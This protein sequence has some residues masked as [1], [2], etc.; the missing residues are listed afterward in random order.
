MSIADS[1]LDNN[2]TTTGIVVVVYKDPDTPADTAAVIERT[3]DIAG[4][5]DTGSWQV[6][7]TIQPCDNAGSHF[8]DYLPLTN[9][10]YWYR[11]RHTHPAFN[12]SD[13]IFETSGSA[14][15]IPDID[16]ASKP[17]LLS[18]TPL[19]LVMVV[20]GSTT[21]SWTVVP[22]V[23][24]PVVGTLVTPPTITPFVSGN[25]GNI[26]TGSLT[27]SF[28]INRPT[29]SAALVDSFVVFRSISQGYLSGFD[30]VE[31]RGTS[32]TLTSSSFL[33]LKLS[34]TSSTLT[35]VGVSASVNTSQPVG[36]GILSS[37][38]VGTI[39]QNGVGQWTINRPTAGEGSVSFIVT[40]STPSIIPDTDTLYISK[41][42][43]PYLTVQSTNLNST[44]QS[45]TASVDIFD[46]NNQTTTLTGIS[47]SVLSGSL[48]GLGA[49][50]IG[51]VT[52]SAGMDSYLFYITRPDY[53][54]GTG[55]LTFLATKTGYTRDSDS[56]EVPERVDGLAR[57]SLN[58]T[59]TSLTT[60]SM[61]VSASAIDPLGI[62]T[63][64]LSTTVSPS[65][66]FTVTGTNPYT[67]TRPPFES[68]SGQFIV[69][70]TATGRVA[71][72]DSVTVPAMA[73]EGST[74]FRPWVVSD[75]QTYYEEPGMPGIRFRLGYWSGSND[76]SPTPLTSVDP[77]GGGDIIFGIQTPP[78][79]TV[80]P[81]L[82]SVLY[83]DTVNEYF[84]A[85]ASN[86][87]LPYGPDSA[88]FYVN[89]NF[90]RLQA[91][92]ETTYST[93]IP[94]NNVAVIGGIADFAALTVNGNPVTGGAGPTGP[95]GPTGPSGPYGLNW[96]GDWVVSTAYVLRDTVYYDGSSWVCITAHTSNA[97]NVPGV[98]SEWEIL[99]QRGGTGATG[100]QGPSG[101]TGPN[102]PVTISATGPSGGGSQG[103][104]WVVV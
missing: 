73:Q 95:T 13:Y 21:G 6:V 70:A 32:D 9:T 15:I 62:E 10:V 71:D 39:T 63:P 20:S 85:T 102:Y 1:N 59:V 31:L 11:A 35:S 36:F 44:G 69:T 101:P 92:E 87:G 65:G 99:A 97:F 55:R 41:D 86:A 30:K 45:V 27:G 52:Q 22:Q 34:V 89:T 50:Q 28:I 66:R 4:A 64:S 53:G 14:T 80:A 51:P 17:W 67:I 29:G 46:S 90:P 7:G 58:L 81:E 24:Q 100:V 82:G 94:A 16:F 42:P 60:S 98:G 93:T 84:Y 26:I 40:G 54:Q 103:Q 25:V 38:N 57:L 75:V 104:L 61:I 3:T 76:S 47:L 18:S 96:D 33:Q 5:P 77:I 83:W 74:G 43:A 56:L 8:I 49:T 12:S 68:G 88:S 79:E 23:N 19:Q 91:T 72:T 2:T 48:T 37:E 78:N